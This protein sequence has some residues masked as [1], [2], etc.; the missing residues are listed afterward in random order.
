LNFLKNAMI[1]KLITHLQG[2]IV[3]QVCIMHIIILN[4]NLR[5]KNPKIPQIFNFF[6]ESKCAFQ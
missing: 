3:I 2:N 5:R 6:I 1:F 4:T